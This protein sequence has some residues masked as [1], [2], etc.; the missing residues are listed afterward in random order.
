MLKTSHFFIDQTESRPEA[1]IEILWKLPNPVETRIENYSKPGGSSEFW[2]Y[3]A[4][5]PTDL[6]N[7]HLTMLSTMT[8]ALSMDDYLG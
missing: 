8:R 5:E 4:R 7:E 3:L 1:L 2:I 6:V